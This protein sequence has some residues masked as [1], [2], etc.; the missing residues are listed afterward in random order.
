MDSKSSYTIQQL[1]EQDRPRERLLRTGPEA[2]SSAELIALILGSGTKSMPVLQLAHE[3]LSRFGCLSKL[4]EATVQELCQIKGVGQ[5]KAIQL[6]A[7]F[8]LGARASRQTI[9]PKYKIEHPAHAYHLIKEE[10]ENEK[11]ELFVVVLLDVK[12]YVINHQIVAVGT[13]SQ[14]LVH[15]REVFYPAIRH[16]AASLILAHNHPSGDPTPSSEDYAV[17]TQLIDVGGVIGISVNDHLIIGQQAY[18]SLRRQGFS[19]TPSKSSK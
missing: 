13:L 18:I 19:F 6:K 8:N 15:P 5:A 7:C 3:I 9:P 10:L 12:N 4:A 17:T 2:L 16:K 14:T 11:R 1:P